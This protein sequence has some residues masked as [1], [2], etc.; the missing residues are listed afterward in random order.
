MD[1][2]FLGT[3]TYKVCKYVSRKIRL[4]S[5]IFSVTSRVLA[6]ASNNPGVRYIKEIDE[7]KV[8]H[9]YPAMVYDTP[10]TDSL[11]V[12]VDEGFIND[13][14]IV[15]KNY[16]ILEKEMRTMYNTFIIG[17]I[18]WTLLYV[19]LILYFAPNFCYLSRYRN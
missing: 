3:G 8:F 13:N 7:E 14:L 11:F 19:L 10:E 5:D 18:L 9:F 1:L 12:Y 6:R 4:S 16:Q 15:S 17:E 2:L